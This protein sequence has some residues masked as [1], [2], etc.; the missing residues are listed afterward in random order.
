MNEC[1]RLNFREAL[2]DVNQVRGG[3]VGGFR[4]KNSASNLP[5]DANSLI[6]ISS[7]GDTSVLPYER[8]V[9][10]DGILE[11]AKR[12]LHSQELSRCVW[13]C[14]P[15]LSFAIRNAIDDSLGDGWLLRVGKPKASAGNGNASE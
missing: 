9:L 15:V 10:S 12:C 3:L 4:G 8:D 5:R 11:L 7:L 6:A 13:A 2:Q 1:G 14:V